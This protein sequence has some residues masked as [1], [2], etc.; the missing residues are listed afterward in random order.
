MANFSFIEVTGAVRKWVAG[1]SQVTGRQSD[2]LAL[3][4]E[5]NV[6][7]CVCVYVRIKGKMNFPRLHIFLSIFSYFT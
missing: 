7:L 4:K 6:C 2:W 1:L 5:E 3:F